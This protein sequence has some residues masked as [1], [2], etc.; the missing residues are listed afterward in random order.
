[1]WDLGLSDV[2]PNALFHSFLFCV[3]PKPRFMRHDLSSCLAPALR[4]LKDFKHNLHFSESKTT[5]HVHYRS[6][7]KKIYDPHD[8]NTITLALCIVCS[9]ASIMSRRR[10][11]IQLRRDILTSFLLFSNTALVIVC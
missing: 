1:M 6:T 2:S 7:D 4:V 10:Y 11:R 9:L 3:T 5:A 8:V